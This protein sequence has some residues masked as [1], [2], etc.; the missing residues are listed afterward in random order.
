L[1]R[2]RTHHLRN[3]QVLR[4]SLAQLLAGGRAHAE[5]VATLREIPR[6]C[7][8]TKPRG[9]PHTPWELLEHLRI[10]QRDILDFSRD[11]EHPSP[12]WP[13][14]FWPASSAPP[15]SRAWERSVRSF[16][17]DLAA[18]Q[19]VVRDPR[20]DLLAPLPGTISTWLGQL[21][22][23]ASHNSYHLGQLVLLAKQLGRGKR[24]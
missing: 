20:R 24:S 11:P 8:G 17:A 15:D 2:A 22:L 4:K 19:R 13:E 7:R 14:G 23:A 9:A 18:L 5:V 16:A 6:A 10:A 12:A 3:S 1:S 21:L